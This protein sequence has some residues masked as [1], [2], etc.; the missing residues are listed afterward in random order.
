LP[1]AEVSVKLVEAM[2][3]VTAVAVQQPLL[4]AMRQLHIGVLQVVS[5]QQE[6]ATQP[7]EMLGPQVLAT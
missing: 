5:I 6:M 4:V 1:L 3:A 2:L 7:L